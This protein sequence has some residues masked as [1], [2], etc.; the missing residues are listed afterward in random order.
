MVNFVR[1]FRDNNYMLV[2]LEDYLKEKYILQPE[3]WSETCDW[4]NKVFNIQTELEYNILAK[5]AQIDNFDVFK[6]KEAYAKLTNEYFNFDNDIL[7]FISFL[8]GTSYFS[9]I[10]NP[11]IEE[12]LNAVDINHP[13]KKKENVGYGYSFFDALQYE[14][15]QNIIRK[16]LLF[17]LRWISSQ[18]G[19]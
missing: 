3:G 5:E 1:I 16:D 17:T 6:I 19:S 14:F 9:K 13:F 10:G 4:I 12:W 11:T 2:S 15:G 8:L 18:G 7:K